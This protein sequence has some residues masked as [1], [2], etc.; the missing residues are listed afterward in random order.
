VYFFLAMEG[1]A[2]MRRKRGEKSE[3]GSIVEVCCMV[4]GVVCVV[5]GVVCVVVGVVCVIVGVLCV[6]W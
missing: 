3:E 5:V 4:F 1:V 2:R 6:C